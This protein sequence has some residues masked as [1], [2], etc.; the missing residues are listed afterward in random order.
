[1]GISDYWDVVHCSESTGA[2]K[3]HPLSFFKLAEAMSLP[4]EN[5]LYVGNSHS[6]DVVGAGRAGMK[7]A[8]LKHAFSGK[9]NPN[10]D[11]SFI[12]YRQLYDFMLH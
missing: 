10:P 8:W 2:I 4:P 11:F 1:L 6:Y 3:P 12:N 5:I 9:R 7:T